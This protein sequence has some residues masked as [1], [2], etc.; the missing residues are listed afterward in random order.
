MI[1][2]IIVD[3]VVGIIVGLGTG[4][5]P[6]SC[7]LPPPVIILH[8][9]LAPGQLAR[10]HNHARGGRTFTTIIVDHGASLRTG[11]RLMHCHLPHP[12]IIL[13]VDAAPRQLACRHVHVGG[14]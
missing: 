13:H 3:V 1:I 14:G 8:I 10:H 6:T 5:R 11:P 9:D 7:C 12:V 4:P 2:A